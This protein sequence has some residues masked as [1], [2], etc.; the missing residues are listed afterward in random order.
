[1]P[2]YLCGNH[3]ELSCN[4]TSV[5]FALDFEDGKIYINFAADL[6]RPL[7]KNDFTIKYG[8][9]LTY[10]ASSSSLFR[11][12]N[13]HYYIQTD[14]SDCNLPITVDLLFNFS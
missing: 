8:D 9:N 5:G 2:T 3:T 1:V 14:L 7:K 4:S 11:V 6:G 13:M 10:N 12:D